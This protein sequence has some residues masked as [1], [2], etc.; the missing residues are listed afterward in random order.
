VCKLWALLLVSFLIYFPLTVTAQ[1]ATNALQL[2]IPVERQ[3]GPGQTHEFTVDLKENFLI[4]LVVEQRGVDVIVK[5]FSPSGK[6]VGEYDS[7]NG[8]EGPEHVSFVAATAGSYRVAV[9]PLDPSNMATGR[10]EIKVLEL[11]PANEEE[12]KAS[13]NLQVVKARGIALLKE[14]EESLPLI[15]SP[16]TRIRIQF[17]VGQGISGVNRA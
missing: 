7:P 6:S 16:Y 13:E 3:L 15:K 9:S 1:K 17:T 5:A 14:V 4:Q 8:T 10:Y 2:G 12:L 11:R